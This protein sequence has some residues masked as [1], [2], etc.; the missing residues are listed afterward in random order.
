MQYASITDRHALDALAQQQPAMKEDKQASF[1]KLKNQVRDIVVE[2][3]GMDDIVDD[4]PLMNSGLTSQSAVLLRNALSK[5]F[6][7][8]SLPF[9]MMFDS[10]SINALTEFLN[11]RM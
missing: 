7:G 9:T 1:A 3:A 8:P 10:P 2:I 4:D 11:T 5:A 6:P